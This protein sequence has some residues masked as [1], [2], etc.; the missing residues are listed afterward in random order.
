MRKNKTWGG[1][2]EKEK[3]L[4]VKKKVYV[5]GGGRFHEKI[6]MESAKKNMGGGSAKVS[7]PP[8]K[9]LK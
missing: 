6:C 2:L 7:I 3:C 8:P 4:E 9:D 1:D 5:C